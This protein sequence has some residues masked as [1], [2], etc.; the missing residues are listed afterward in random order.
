LSTP[1]SVGDLGE[2]GLIALIRDRLPASP[3]WVAVGLGDDAAVVEPARNTFDVLT[4]DALVEGVHFDRAFTPPA[5]I[6]H[7][8]LAVNLSDLAAMGATPRVA[9][10]SLVLPPDLAVADLAA[11]VDGLLA[12]AAAHGVALV[13]GNITR[14][15][16]P[17]MLD[18]TA[19]GAVRPRRVLT[20][21]G[22]RPGDQVWVSGAIG[23]AAAGLASLA[24]GAPRDARMATCEAAF[25]TPDPRVRLGRLLGGNRAASACVDLSDGLADGLHQ[26]AQSSG[27]GF[28]I[29]ARAVPVPEAAREW[30]AAHGGDA[31]LPALTGGDDYELLFTVR[32]RTRR[33]M[34]TVR[35]QA[36]GVP[37][38]CIGTVV[39]AREVTL[40]DGGVRTPIPSGYVHFR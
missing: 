1:S 20:R 21:T 39:P 18:V 16:G 22:A 25:L 31:L 32:P 33:R 23:A 26:L 15:P 28:E 29:D 3:R 9:L 7:R 24:S 12:L 13:G 30:F 38:T 14:S 40:V 27:V 8:A 10:L 36:R 5:A 4:T 11:M 17:L 35:R 37:L 6:G 19:V 2:H 34:E